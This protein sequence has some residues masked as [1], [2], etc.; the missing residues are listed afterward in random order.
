MNKDEALA[1]EIDLMEK[2]I[3]YLRG[4][5]RERAKMKYLRLL[6]SCGKNCSLDK[7]IYLDRI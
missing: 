4:R 3:I 2:E 1:T 6:R 5:K 7:P